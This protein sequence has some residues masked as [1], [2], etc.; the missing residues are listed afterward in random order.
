MTDDIMKIDVVSFM[1]GEIIVTGTDDINNLI[2]SLENN[3]KVILEQ[4]K[5]DCTESVLIFSSNMLSQIKTGDLVI[6]GRE[7]NKK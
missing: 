2:K 6:K 3:D 4:K 5:D 7:E 1:K